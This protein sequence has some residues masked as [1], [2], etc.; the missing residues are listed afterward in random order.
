MDRSLPRLPIPEK[1][2]EKPVK[3]VIQKLFAF[4][5]DAIGP[6]ALVLDKS[7]AERGIAGCDLVRILAGADSSICEYSLEVFRLTVIVNLGAG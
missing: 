5:K 3:L 4:Q 2:R 1:A 6:G 7:D